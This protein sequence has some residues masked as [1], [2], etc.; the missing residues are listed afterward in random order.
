MTISFIAAVSKNGVIGENNSLIWKIPEDL[1]RFRQLTTG[2]PIIMGR[3]TFES[4]GKPLPNRTNIILTRDK[5]YK[6]EG[7]FV[8]HSVDDALEAGN[9]AEEIMIIGGAQIYA[10]FLP[11]ADKMYLT[12]IDKDFEGD[13][14]FPNYNKNEWKEIGREERNDGNLK[15]AFV[16]FAKK[17]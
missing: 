8:V 4:I 5:N 14:F 13:A 17:L 15:Y 11:V 3:K 16:D 2:K 12:F 7:C 1:K 6:A 10:Q 9:G